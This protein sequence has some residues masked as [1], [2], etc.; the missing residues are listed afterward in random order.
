MDVPVVALSGKTQNQSYGSQE[1]LKFQYSGVYLLISVRIYLCHKYL[2]I[3]CALFI[4]V[5]VIRR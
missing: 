2:Y 5:Q 4:D 3:V 1:T